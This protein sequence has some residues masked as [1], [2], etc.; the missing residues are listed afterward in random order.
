MKI[1]QLTPNRVILQELGKRLA[2]SRK[3]QGLSQTALAEEAGIGVATLRRIEGG[4]DSQMETWIKVMK[5]LR[6]WSAVDSFLPETLDSPM[7]EV[8]SSR[9]RKKSHSK[10][11]GAIKWGDEEP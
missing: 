11:E 8:L 4:Q 5:S 9:K 6:M 1:D 2:R 10:S 3:Q 7:R